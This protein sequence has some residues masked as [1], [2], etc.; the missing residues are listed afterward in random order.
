MGYSIKLNSSMQIG[1]LR[2]K[3]GSFGIV[4][5]N[6]VAKNIDNLKHLQQEEDVWCYDRYP[7]QSSAAKVLIKSHHNNKEKECVLWSVNHYLGLNRHP[8]IIKAAQDAL[9]IYGTGSG[10]SGMSGGLCEL[11]IQIED[12]VAQLFNKEAGIIFPTGYTA[13]VGAISS[14]C[15]GSNSLILIDR[16]VHASIL[17]GCKFSGAKYLPFKHNSVDDLKRKINK[18]KDIYKQIFVIIESVYSMSGDVAPLREIADLKHMNDFFLYVDEAH[19][20]GLYGKNGGGLCLEM[21]ITDSVDMLM[22]T[23]SKS[24]ASVG[25]VVAGKRELCSLIQVTAN[26]YIFQCCLTPSSAAT[27]LAALDIIEKEPIHRDTLH[28]NNRYF[29]EK[30]LKLNFDLGKSKSPVVPLYIRNQTIMQNMEKELFERGIFSV[31]LTYPG[32]KFNEV[33]FRFIVS[34]SHTREHIDYTCEVLSDLGKK[35][36]FIKLEGIVACLSGDNRTGDATEQDV[37]FFTN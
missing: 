33:R 23:L 26:A 34:A 24:T 18:Y 13:N 19:S 11:H 21:G 12:R 1:M 16:E 28:D 10:T 8:K 17:D 6:D 25:G 29:R 3:L 4:S 2:Q 27:V 22:T 31:S 20:F 32:V 14:L 36:G 9:E 7:K 30:L 15:A 35:Y 5:L 37:V